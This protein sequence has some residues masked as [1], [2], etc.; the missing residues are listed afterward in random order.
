MLTASVLL[1]YQQKLIKQN[2]IN[3]LTTSSTLSAIKQQLISLQGGDKINN[4]QS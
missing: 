2:G 3:S 4:Q 1:E